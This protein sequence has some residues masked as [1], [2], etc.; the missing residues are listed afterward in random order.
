M[1]Q[2]VSMVTCF[3]GLV[4]L[5]ASKSAIK[6]QAWYNNARM[7][8]LNNNLPQDFID[9]LPNIVPPAI[10]DTVMRSFSQLK[11][12][13]FRVNHLLPSSQE[14]I[15][16]MKENNIL[17]SPIA[18]YEDAFSTTSS[19]RELTALSA[20]K[21]GK[22]YIQGLSSMIPALVLNP[23]PD[24]IVLDIAAA[25]G[26]KTTQIASLMGNNGEIVAN[27]LSRQ[28]IFK[29]K[30]NLKEQ[31]VTNT[32]FSNIPGEN[33]WRKYPEY[34]D[35]TLVDVPC[36]MEGRFNNND[37]DSHK[38]W[39]LKKVK[40]LSHRQKYL[41]RGAITATKVGGTI[42][43]S[44]CTLSPEE[45]EEVID[46][47]LEKEGDAIT[48]ESIEIKNLQLSPGLTLWGNQTYDLSLKNTARI[49]PSD[50]ME[51]FFIAKIHK[52]RSTLTPEMFRPQ[53]KRG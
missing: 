22:F 9:R 35:K 30:A 49:Y 6:E 23:S 43:Y 11:P 19:T 32:T 16:I 7:N 4:N 53:K 51:G 20:F 12:T 40:E 47:I 31:G 13:T 21:E 2:C 48:I 10:F 8:Y 45:N 39:T 3:E 38:D 52:N 18:W 24:E 34:F 1:G 29:L 28:R 27:D 5:T 41:L 33:L 44:T 50:T 26:S 42:V 46:W 14:I 25:P 17:I 15:A 37:S 36:S